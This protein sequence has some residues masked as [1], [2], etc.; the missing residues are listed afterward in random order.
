MHG[1]ASVGTCHALAVTRLSTVHQ[2]WQRLQRLW[3][4]LL[5][6]E[7]PRQVLTLEARRQRRGR[8]MVLVVALSPA[9]PARGAEPAS[10]I[11]AP[12]GQGTEGRNGGGLRCPRATAPQLG[13]RTYVQ[14]VD[15]RQSQ[16][17]KA[18]LDRQLEAISRL[19]A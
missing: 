10:G 13:V 12:F 1:R 16:D 6:L 11:P 15:E 9:G 8:L 2:L 4:Q 19:A 18:R 17:L 3:K 7:M 14:V 5:R